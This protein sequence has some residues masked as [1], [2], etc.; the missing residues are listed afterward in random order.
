MPREG[1]VSIGD[2]T[3]RVHVK[4][5]VSLVW[6]SERRAGSKPTLR[7]GFDVTG[8]KHVRLRLQVFMVEH[9]GPLHLVGS[10]RTSLSIL[11]FKHVSLIMGGERA[12]VFLPTLPL[13]VRGSPHAA[14]LAKVLARNR[15]PRISRL[16]F[17]SL[18][19]DQKENL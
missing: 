7:S 13:A 1:S 12:G 4:C 18:L 14:K 16:E 2:S 10:G 8:G 5:P 15:N 3:I 9:R 17:K 6:V 19:I 11:T